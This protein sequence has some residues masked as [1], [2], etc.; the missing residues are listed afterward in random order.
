MKPEGFTAP[1]TSPT[2]EDLTTNATTNRTRSPPRNRFSNVSL[3]TLSSIRTAILPPYSVVDALQALLRPS[4]QIAT[5]PPDARPSWNCTTSG[6]TSSPNVTEP[7]RYSLINPPSEPIMTWGRS[8]ATQPE[9]ESDTHKFRYSYLI[10]PKNSW[11]ILHLD[12]PARVPGKPKAL[13]G[14]PR[15]PRYWSCDPIT[16][17]LE[18]DLDNTQNIQKINISV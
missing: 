6:P 7:P 9:V 14:K 18:L 17:T 5:S 8:T 4:T 3:L 13:R 2:S 1:E 10:G 12:T 11:A 16:G 15:V